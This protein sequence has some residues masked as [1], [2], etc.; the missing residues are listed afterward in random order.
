MQPNDPYYPPQYGNG[1]PP[2]QPPQGYGYPPAVWFF[3]F[4][5]LHPSWSGY[6]AKW[7]AEGWATTFLVLYLV[8]FVLSFL[9]F[10][11]GIIVTIYGMVM[12]SKHRQVVPAPGAFAGYPP[13]QAVLP[14]PPAP[15]PPA[16]YPP[17]QQ[18]YAPTQVPSYRP[19]VQ[20][21]Q[22]PLPPAVPYPSALPPSGDDTT[23]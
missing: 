2:P 16:P 15:Y 22:E 14:Y 20:Y 12:V 8:C 10:P 4:S 21:P 18:G 17:V 19:L 9:F 6:W 3:P 1:Y 13:Q 5:C 7:K 11:L 23:V